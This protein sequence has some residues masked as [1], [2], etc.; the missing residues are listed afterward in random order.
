MMLCS[1]LKTILTQILELELICFALTLFIKSCQV[2]QV[3][4][5]IFPVAVTGGAPNEM[6]H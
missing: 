1:L 6:Q 2:P 3:N 5:E 4:F